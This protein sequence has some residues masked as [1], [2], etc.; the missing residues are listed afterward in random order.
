MSTRRFCFFIAVSLTT[1]CGDASWWWS[2]KGEDESA[3]NKRNSVDTKRGSLASKTKD[4]S[5]DDFRARIRKMTEAAKSDQRKN[6]AVA[7]D[8]KAKRDAKRAQ[9]DAK[10]AEN[11]ARFEKNKS[12]WDKKNVS[13]IK[14][15]FF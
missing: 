12:T 8:A 5:P 3:N 11:Q 4:D 9:Q 7:A 15:Y 6:M 2:A 1:N 10:W 14:L 13:A